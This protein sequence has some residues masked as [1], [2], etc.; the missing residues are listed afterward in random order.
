MALKASFSSDDNPEVSP[1]TK[2]G[3]KPA[4][5][6]G[7]CAIAARS[8]SRNRFANPAAEP[9]SRTRTT[10][11]RS[12]N[13]P[14]ERS[15]GSAARDK[16]STLMVAPAG[17]SNSVA[18]SPLAVSW[19]GRRPRQAS[20]WAVTCRRVI[21]R[22][23]D[24]ARLPVA[25]QWRASETTT[26][27]ISIR[28]PSD[29]HRAG[30]AEASPLAQSQLTEPAPSSANPTVQAVQARRRAANV[31]AKKPRPMTRP[32]HRPPPTPIAA[33]HQAAKAGATSRRSTRSAG[34]DMDEGG[35]PCEGLCANAVH[36]LKLLDASE[37]AVRLAPV[38]D[39]LRSYRPHPG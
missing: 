24:A 25:G 5:R 11:P 34:S 17:W 19:A 30:A 13:V 29:A 28:A 18:A 8:P 23:A 39:P 12:D 37:A 3:T 1:T 38:Q 7:E 21:G 14:T 31:V 6:G 2:D 27:S 33:A 10:G 32:A 22:T 4:C 16:T 36:L 9:G 26:A 20:P 35:E 15:P